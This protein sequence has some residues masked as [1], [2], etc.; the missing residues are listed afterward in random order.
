VSLK[1]SITDSQ[2]GF[3]AYSKKAI[4]KIFLTESGMGVSTEI[5]LKAAD[6]NLRIGEVPIIVK[7]D[8]DTSTHNP[9]RHG[10]SVFG[11]TLKF[12]LKNTGKLK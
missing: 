11:S 1:E 5:L 8:G 7:Y 12:I 2:S 4:S 10:V 9:F 6:L 3:R